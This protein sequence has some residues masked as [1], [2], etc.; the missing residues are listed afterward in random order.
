MLK[1]HNLSKAQTLACFGDYY[2]VDV[3]QHPQK[4]D[5]ANIRQFMLSGPGGIQFT[6]KN[7]LNIK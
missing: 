1:L 3:L 4:N 6:G 2:R 5:H 7:P